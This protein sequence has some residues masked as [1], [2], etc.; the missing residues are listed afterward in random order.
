M[1]LAS[2]GDNAFQVW[3]LQPGNEGKTYE[4]YEA[5]LRQPATDA[6]ERADEAA[7]KA[8]GAAD[9][10]NSAATAAQGA[11]QNA[12]AAAEEARTN[13]ASA[14]NEA[15][16]AREAATNANN[17]ATTAQGAA[18]NANTAA[19]KANE[20]AGTIDDK[21]GGIQTEL[22]KKADKTEIPTS[23]PANGGNADTLD[24]LGKM[25]FGRV[26]YPI[27]VDD[28]IGFISGGYT[29]QSGGTRPGPGT[30]GSI[31][32]VSNNIQG[33]A[34]GDW[35]FQIAHAHG[36]DRPYW[37]TQYNN[38]GW[39]EW[40]RL[41]F[42]DDITGVTSVRFD[43]VQNAASVSV[44]PGQ[45]VRRVIAY[46]IKKNHGWGSRAAIG[47]TNPSGKFRPVI[48]SAGT[49]DSGTT[50]ADWTFDPA[51]GRI[52]TPDGKQF[53]VNEETITRNSAADINP[54]S[55]VGAAIFG[56]GYEN[57]GWPTTGP[58]ISLGG[59]NNDYPLQLIGLYNDKGFYMRTYNGDT[60]KW[61]TWAKIGLNEDIIGA[62]SWASGTDYGPRLDIIRKGGANPVSATIPRASTAE[63]GVVTTIDQT[64]AGRKSFAAGIDI[65]AGG[66]AVDGGIAVS[67]TIVCSGEVSASKFFADSDVR[68]KKNITAIKLTHNRIKLYEFDIDGKHGYGVIAQ[69]I[70]RLYPSVVIEKENGYKAVNYPEVLVIKC[71]EQDER[72]ETLEKENQELKDRLER[73]E[74][75]LLK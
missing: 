18:Q 73:L 60:K 65:I 36:E 70:E 25:S 9:N 8:Q 51:T 24:G 22:D 20:A 44:D 4:D 29:P 11:T 52:T 69:E 61:N 7:G 54:D 58:F 43:Q 12:N 49:D 27:N 33:P 67:G 59:F 46:Y 64:F 30:Y 32:Q 13:A 5:W 68:L 56:F 1:L 42:T 31:L 26:F 40:K 15:D 28:T 47:L 71:A 45:V 14:K 75:L 2:K 23:L 10:A 21:I 53:A 74:K 34:G 35:V 38:G 17:A 66:M 57:K 19:E 3:L 6:G 41:A 62:A 55:F 48:I 39:T 37:R 50:W 16:A 63:S 72:I